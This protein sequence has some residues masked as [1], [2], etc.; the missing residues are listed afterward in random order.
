MNKAEMNDMP[1][2]TPEKNMSKMDMSDMD[3]DMGGG[4][5]MHMGNLKRKF[6]VS[7]ILTLPIIL[8]S[9]M[10]GMKLPFQLIFHPW[11]DYLVAVIGTIA[12]SYTHLTLP[13]ICSV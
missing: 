5:M 3:M 13:T 2:T 8:M 6:W 4:Q 9:P 7:L 11:S 12:V 1:K 10:M